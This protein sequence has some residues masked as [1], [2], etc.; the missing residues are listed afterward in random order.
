MDD[1]RPLGARS[2]LLSTLLGTDPPV[3]PARAL[4][5]V[6]GLF[7]VAPGTVRT[8][9]SRMVAAGEL[10]V[11]DGRYR[12]VGR[13]LGRREAQTSGRRPPTG[14]WDGGWHLVIVTAESRPIA[15]RRAF[16]THLVD[17]RFGELRPEV[18][19]RPTNLPA[20]APTDGAL[21]T[22]GPLD[23]E[24]PTALAARLWDLGGWA[25]RARALAEELAAATPE[26]E[27]GGDDRIP[28]DFVRS[29]AV[30]RHLRR[31]PL[32][33]AELLPPDW[34]GTELRTAYDRFDALFARRLRDFL[35][36][37]R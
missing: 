35:Q 31:D 5:A 29:A 30:L 21:L 17:H 24:D 27:S 28:V 25:E 10:E 37:S 20:P 34:P 14:R 1:R 19:L 16:R 11:E 22:R 26:L 33:P 18:W 2:I 6:G 23:G 9:L 13:L 8:A 12:L 4:V 15:A 32:L 3:L 36:R 7:D